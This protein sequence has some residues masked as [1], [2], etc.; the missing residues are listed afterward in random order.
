MFAIT[1]Q[2]PL[3]PLATASWANLTACL[4]SLLVYILTTALGWPLVQA[5]LAHMFPPLPS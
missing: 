1:E 2:L 5:S 3:F 4:C